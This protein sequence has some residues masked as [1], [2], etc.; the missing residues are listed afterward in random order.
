MSD[1]VPKPEYPRP[2]WV[3]SDWLNLN[4]EWEFEEDPDLSGLAGGLRSGRSL[5]GRIVVPFA[6]ES[7]LSG[8]GK[9]DFM[10]AVWYRRLFRPPAEWRGRR[11]LLHFGAVDYEA[12]V[13]V[14]GYLAGSHR[15]GQ[16]P[17]EFDITPCLRGG[18]NEVVVRAVDDTR[19]PLQP[20]GKQSDRLESYGC[21]YTR[22]T[23]IWQT[24]WLEAVPAARL[25]RARFL[26]DLEGG[27]LS[28]V[29]KMAG[30]AS[31]QA[32]TAIAR[33][34]GAEVAS[35]EAEVNGDSAALTLELGDARR[36]SPDDPFLYELEL[37]LTAGDTVVDRIESYF[38]MR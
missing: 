6:P 35:A 21:F 11:L 29:V 1:G 26:P 32:V 4:G 17:F 16:S 30:A 3:R 34:D 24:V 2:Q 20:S 12:T 5:S 38:G 37:R 9:T 18:E 10:P 28:V 14:N 13:W 31:G 27:R 23:G 25:E 8:I 36:W 7:Q 19:S 33:A 22:T 15:G